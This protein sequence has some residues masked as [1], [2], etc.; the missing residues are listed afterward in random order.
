LFIGRSLALSLMLSQPLG[1]G[2][3]RVFVDCF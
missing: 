3:L 1:Y 2:D